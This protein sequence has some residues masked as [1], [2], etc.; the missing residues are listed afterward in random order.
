MSLGKHCNKSYSHP[1]RIIVHF[2]VKEKHMSTLIYII[3]IPKEVMSYVN[4]QINQRLKQQQGNTQL[5]D[6][7]EH[8]D[9][10]SMLSKQRGKDLYPWLCD[11]DPRRKMTNQEILEKY[12]D[13]SDSDLSSAEKRSLYK[14]LVKYKDAFLS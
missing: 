3:K 6:R 9:N 8:D 5:V 14:V 11:D 1:L 12:I 4:S 13:L 7:N 2:L 10:D